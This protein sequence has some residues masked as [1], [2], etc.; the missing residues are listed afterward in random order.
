MT[1]VTAERLAKWWPAAAI[2]GAVGGYLLLQET[3]TTADPR[4]RSALC[5]AGAVLVLARAYPPKDQPRA[6]VVMCLLLA[7]WAGLAI[8]AIAGRDVDRVAGD[9]EARL[10][11]HYHYYL[12]AKYFEEL[13]YDGLYEQTLAADRQGGRKLRGAMIIRDLGSY[14]PVPAMYEARRRSDAWTDARWSSFVDD[15]AFFA[16]RIDPDSFRKILRDRGYNAT[17][18]G[19]VVYRVTSWVPLSD[20]ALAM[21]GLLDPALLI[22]ALVFVGRIFGPLRA[23]VAGAWL[24]VFYGNEMHLLGGPILHDYLAALLLMA[25]ATHRGRP[26]LA[27]GLLGY[28]AMVRVFPGLLLAG[29]VVWTVR[30]MR[31]DGAFPQFTNRFARGVGAAVLVMGLLG[32]LAG[33]GVSG[34]TEWADNISLHS[35]NH[36]FGDKRLGLQHIFTHDW[37][38]LA[39]GDW[40]NKE[41]RYDTWPEQKTAWAGVALLLLALWGAASWRAAE[42]ERDPLDSLAF[43]LVVVFAGIVLSRYYWSA[44]VLLLLVGG[45]ERDGPREAWLA[46]GLLGLVAVYYLVA[47]N[48]EDQFGRYVLANIGLSVFLVLALVHRLLEPAAPTRRGPASS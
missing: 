9:R 29:L 4:F 32:C 21:V 47:G 18:A 33:R 10:W 23:L 7:L 46:A 6:P 25:C 48:T 22:L 11:S 28:A 26:M 17:P 16:D 27:G 15:V 41:H 13:G 34:W 39:F 8:G 30:A 38:G 40:R 3:G 2:V 42:H 31:R 1:D 43:A 36:R 20:G 44:A 19:G 35:D 37:G 12:G 24:C 14:D 45:R 5:A